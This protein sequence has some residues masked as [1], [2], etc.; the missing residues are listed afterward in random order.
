[1][2]SPHIARASGYPSHIPGA[3][4]NT[5]YE[6]FYQ[7]YSGKTLQILNMGKFQNLQFQNLH[8]K[9]DDRVTPMHPGRTPQVPACEEHAGGVRQWQG[10]AV[11]ACKF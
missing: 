7:T 2:S 6:F 11:Q 3:L 4:E 9:H 8:Q 5:R 1:M 10:V